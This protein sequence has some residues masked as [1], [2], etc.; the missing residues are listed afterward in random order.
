LRYDNTMTD[1]SAVASI[2]FGHMVDLVHPVLSA[3]RSDLFHDAV[4]LNEKL[5][6]TEFTFFYAFDG[7]G[8]D[9]AVDET[10]ISPREHLFRLTVTLVDGSATLKVE[11]A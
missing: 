2:V 1:L 7:S 8:T 6:G 5:T 4:F 10:G 9:I 11:G 3:Y